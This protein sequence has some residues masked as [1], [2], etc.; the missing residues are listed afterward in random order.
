MHAFEILL[1]LMVVVWI[2]GKIFRS[3]SLPVVFGELLGG[4]LLGP[5]FLG[6]MDADTELI[7]L[8]AEL[9]IFFLMLHAGL[10]TDPDK[11]FHSS[12]KSIFI[13]LGSLVIPLVGGTW[14]GTF[15]GVPF[16][17]SL[18]LG[19]VLSTTSIIIAVRIFKEAGI[20]KTPV[21]NLVVTSAVLNDILALAVFSV[22]L[23]TLETGTLDPFII[24]GM[25][26]KI[27]LFFGVVLWLG[28]VTA[29]HF[30]KALQDKG[31]TFA[32][33][34]ALSLG[35]FAEAMGLHAIL[36]AF[37]AGLFIR[38]EIVDERKFKKIEDRIYGLSYSFLGPIFF[39]SLAFYITFDAV[40]E[41]PTFL[42][43]CI[44]V[45]TGTK[46]I[47]GGVIARLQ[48]VS[49]KKSSIVGFSMNT[50]ATM[51]LVFASVGI[52]QGLISG[53]LFSILVLVCF[54]TTLISMFSIRGL[55]K[56]LQ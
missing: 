39:V 47:G 44:L 40:L 31:F 26:G 38:E 46:F 37:L 20:Q 51:G 8:C 9:G 41:N 15:F 24:L 48:G 12:G 25:F 5:L 42:I 36:G 52:K 10:E 6:L 14:L 49:W 56:N 7:R 50:H 19:A 55:A 30:P 43:A 22:I 29:P 34:V 2:F 18:F 21:S 32:L 53:E 27:L 11:I 28:H 54:G 1:V 4:L 45:A 17:E 33:I 16:L 13:A 35:V 3:L 23:H